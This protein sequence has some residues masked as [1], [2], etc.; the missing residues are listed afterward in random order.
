MY[1]QMQAMVTLSCQP[2][3]RRFGTRVRIIKSRFRPFHCLSN[4]LLQQILYAYS[5]LG[6]SLKFCFA[7]WGCGVR[8]AE[9]KPAPL[10]S[11]RAKRRRHEIPV[12]SAE[13]LTFFPTFKIVGAIRT[14]LRIGE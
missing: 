11:G 1:A 8:R 13:S 5:C 12:H 10:A 3:I 2:A 14:K 4:G 9:K 6:A 7:D